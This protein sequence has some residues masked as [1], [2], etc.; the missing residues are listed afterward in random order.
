MQ[1]AWSFTSHQRSHST[2]P[3][4]IQD[5]CNSSGSSR[6]SH[7]CPTQGPS[8]P[9]TGGCRMQD[10]ECSQCHTRAATPVS[11]TPSLVHR[12]A[13]HSLASRLCRPHMG[14]PQAPPLRCPHPCCHFRCCHFIVARPAPLCM[15]ITCSQ[16]GLYLLGGAG[17]GHEPRGSGRAGGRLPTKAGG[18]VLCCSL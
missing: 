9:C 8:T 17:A 16:A 12:P 11:T 4:T 5:F 3:L 10:S 18:Q 7:T 14:G 2:Q 6:G 1:A 13:P 15:R